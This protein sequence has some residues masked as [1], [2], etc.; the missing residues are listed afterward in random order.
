LN[1]CSHHHHL[2]ICSFCF[3]FP[4][5]IA[6][7]FSHRRK[8]KTTWR[9]LAC[10]SVRS[11]FAR[12]VW[13][14]RE[15]SRGSR[16]CIQGQIGDCAIMR[17][18][19]LQAFLSCHILYRESLAA[20]FTIESALRANQFSG[21]VFSRG[22]HA[23]ERL[24][25]VVN[26]ACHHGRYPAAVARPRDT[27]DVAAAVKAARQLNLP[28]GVRSGGHSYNCASLKHG[29]LLVDL[30]R[31]NKVHMLPSEQNVRNIAWKCTVK[32]AFCSPLCVI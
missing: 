3:P 10:P 22:S 18:C 27:A 23:Y 14:K 9:A 17:V 19:V 8:G 32:S 25:R 28:L 5:D 21:S 7:V 30:R 29:S 26:G 2:H 13:M 6:Q 15:R 16:S 1:A 12:E 11:V 4:N 20:N 24:R 31:L